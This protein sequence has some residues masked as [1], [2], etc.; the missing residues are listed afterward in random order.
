MKAAAGRYRAVAY[1]LAKDGSQ[2][3]EWEDGLAFDERNGLFAVADGV[4][5]SYRSGEWARHLVSDFAGRF[6]A[7]GPVDGRLRQWLHQRV[8][9]WWDELPRAENWW[10]QDADADGSAATLL[11]LRLT[12]R[13]DERILWESFSIGDCCLFRVKGNNFVEQLLVPASFDSHPAV[14][15]SQR[16][17]ADELLPEP[18]QFN[19][20]EAL[21]GEYFVLTSDALGDALVSYGASISWRSLAWMGQD[22]FRDMVEALRDNGAIAND[23]A[24]LL[25]VAVQ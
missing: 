21:P 6:P 1:W 19:R 2:A 23:D 15:S 12:R 20:G 24:S 25:V 18:P 13:N 7:D 9:A 4:S 8:E 16:R 22:A 3:D 5:N 17:S 10:E 11:G 14:V